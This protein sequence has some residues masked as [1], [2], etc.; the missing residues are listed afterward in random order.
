MKP[1]TIKSH[2][3]DPIWNY[4]VIWHELQAARA[5]LEKLLTEMAS[6]EKATYESARR[7]RS[8]ANQWRKQTLSDIYRDLDRVMSKFSYPDSEVNKKTSPVL[9]GIGEA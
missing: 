3:P 8:F 7:R 9:A 4:T 2:T 1:A 5:Q 6:I